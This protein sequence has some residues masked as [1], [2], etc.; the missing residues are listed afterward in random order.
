MAT[1]KQSLIAIQ[2]GCDDRVPSNAFGYISDL[3]EST[4]TPVVIADRLNMLERYIPDLVAEYRATL[5]AA[6][7]GSRTSEKKTAAAR[8]NASKPRPNAQGKPKPRKPKTE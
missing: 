8:A 6:A 2:M 3:T 1:A 5:A 4:A 7:L